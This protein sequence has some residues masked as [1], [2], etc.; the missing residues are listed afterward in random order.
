M[1]R[2]FGPYGASSGS[3]APA[4]QLFKSKQ[5]RHHFSPEDD[6]RIVEAVGNQEYPNWSEI[7]QRVPGKTGRQ[8][9]ERFQHYLSPNLVQ[10][11]WTVA[12]D[13]LIRKLYGEYGP[14][15]ARIA[16][17]F[18]GQRT[19]NNIKNRWNN[20]VAKNVPPRNPGEFPLPDLPRTEFAISPRPAQ[21]G[22]TDRPPES[23]SDTG[24]SDPLGETP[25]EWFNEAAFAD[26]WPL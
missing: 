9:R 24:W 22:V 7:A 5:T 6:E 3:Q 1:P 19:N 25:I 16:M 10:A 12:E 20:H 17:H 23:L 13:E 8:C 18:N 21:H 2:N 11:P 14:N 4:A 15:W 26:E